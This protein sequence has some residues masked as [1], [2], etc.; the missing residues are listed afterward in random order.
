MPGCSIA[1]GV[2]L[3]DHLFWRALFL[4]MMSALLLY[5]TNISLEMIFGLGDNV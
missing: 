1:V 3:S 2:R 4:W 5:L